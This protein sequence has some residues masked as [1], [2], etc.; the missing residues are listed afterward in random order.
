MAAFRSPSSKASATVDSSGPSGPGSAAAPPRDEAGQPV[1][2]PDFMVGIVAA[3]NTRITAL[4]D[5][6]DARWG[7]LDADLV[8]PLHALR[9]LVVA[10]GKRLR[11]AFC[12]WAFVGR[13]GDPG[14]PRV[15]DAGAAL[16]M[17]HVS[18]LSTT[19]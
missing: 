5:D 11:P 1:E 7:A 2:A 14:D 3:V 12:H 4:L 16:E 19:T 6:E 9:T 10:G 13:G 8:D 18:A 15:V 17:L